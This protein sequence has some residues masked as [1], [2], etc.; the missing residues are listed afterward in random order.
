MEN[1]AGLIDGV[2]TALAN[3]LETCA[4]TWQLS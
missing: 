2:G 3:L 1:G 4:Y